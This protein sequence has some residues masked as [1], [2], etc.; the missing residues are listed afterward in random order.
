MEKIE[1]IWLCSLC[2]KDTKLWHK[3]DFDFEE[4]DRDANTVGTVKGKSKSAN[5]KPKRNNIDLITLSSDEEEEDDDEGEEED[6]VEFLAEMEGHFFGNQD[7]S[8]VK[9]FLQSFVM[10]HVL[11]LLFQAEYSEGGDA[12]DPFGDISDAEISEVTE[13]SEDFDA[14]EVMIVS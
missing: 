5:A 2:V 13:S 6:E 7:T 11:I 10:S 9:I 1:D 4:E 14:G 3:E 8:E 12:E